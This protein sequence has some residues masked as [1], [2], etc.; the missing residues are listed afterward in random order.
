M[1]YCNSQFN[2]ADV[3]TLNQT[4]YLTTDGQPAQIK[5]PSSQKIVSLRR[6]IT[7]SYGTS[8]NSKAKLV[9]LI[10]NALLVTIAKIKTIESPHSKLHRPI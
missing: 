7:F 6:E 2:A 8:S 1:L 3:S 5:Q 9:C 4:V 10:A